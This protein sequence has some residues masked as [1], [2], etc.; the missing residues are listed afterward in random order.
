MKH[1]QITSRIIKVFYEVYNELGY[2]LTE[3]IYEKAMMIALADEG[4]KVECQKSLKVHFRGKLIGEFTVDLVVD[5]TVIVELKAASNI[6]E[7]HE[8]QLLNYLK[9]SNLEVGLIL[10][11]GPKPGMKRMVFDN[12]LKYPKQS[13]IKPE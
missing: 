6:V 8:A 13:T 11:F 2:G 12:E 10:N 5:D 3:K 7:A 4:L 1:E 9:A